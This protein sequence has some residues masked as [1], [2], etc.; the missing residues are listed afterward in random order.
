MAT[1]FVTHILLISSRVSFKCSNQK[2]LRFVT[3]AFSI[4]N[5]RCFARPMKTKSQRVVNFDA[6]I[7]RVDTDWHH[8][9][10]NL[11][12]HRTVGAEERNKLTLFFI[13]IIYLGLTTLAHNTSLQWS[14]LCGC[15]AQENVKYY[16]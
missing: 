14:P 12:K 8:T 5:E 4:K 11:I 7:A 3:K 6:E 15:K 16:S 13:I 10:R 9:T 2:S 1:K